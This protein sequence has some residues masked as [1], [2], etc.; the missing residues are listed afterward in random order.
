MTTTPQEPLPEPEVVPSGDPSPIQT[1]EPSPG[2]DEEPEVNPPHDP[3]PEGT[4]QQLS[5]SR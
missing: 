2:P 4:G 3:L 5:P 1:P